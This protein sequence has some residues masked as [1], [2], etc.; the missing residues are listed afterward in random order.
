MGTRS[1][2]AETQLDTHLSLDADGELHV[3]Q[4]PVRDLAQQF[5]TPLH[6]ISGSRLRDNY[7]R[8]R[9]A[10]ATRWG[11]GVNVHF[12]IKSNPALA[13]RVQAQ[14]R[15]QLRLSD[16]RPGPHARIPP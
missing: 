11:A 10:F 8:I 6:V 7:R 3:E 9:D 13:V 14:V 5:G 12:A 4:V 2:I 1:M 16:H 15:V